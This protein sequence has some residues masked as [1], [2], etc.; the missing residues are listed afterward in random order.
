[1]HAASRMEEEALNLERELLGKD[2]RLQGDIRLTAPEG[3]A[4][5][6]LTPVLAE[7]CRLHP[8]IRV[9][10]VVTN[11]SLVLARREADL[12]V[13]VTSSPPDTSL[14]RRIGEFNFCAYASSRYLKK[15]PMTDLAEHHWV[16]I[17]DEADW[18]VPLIWKKKEQAREKTV[19][20]SSL[21][22]TAINAAKQ[23][24]GVILL[25]CFLGDRDKSLKRV[26]EPLKQLANELWVLTHPDLRHTARVRALM[27]FIYESLS[28]LQHEFSGA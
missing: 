20:S 15:Y 8:A 13:R 27:M 1:M 24:M 14:G 26:G 16:T 21:T 28:P 6:M 9:E 11:A 19:F 25:P 3:I 10:V 2:F 18:L 7:F 17:L 23:G 4:T 12:A 5:Y 22:L